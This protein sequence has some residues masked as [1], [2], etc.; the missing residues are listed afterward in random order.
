MAEQSPQPNL[1]EK[2]TLEESR[3]PTQKDLVAYLIQAGL[4]FFFLVGGV[5]YTFSVFHTNGHVVPTFNA[6]A[7]FGCGNHPFTPK[8]SARLYRS[9]RFFSRLEKQ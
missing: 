7:R 1:P 5:F 9:R 8:T 6:P 2:P 4:L 3:R